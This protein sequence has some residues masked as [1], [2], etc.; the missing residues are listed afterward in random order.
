MSPGYKLEH[1]WLPKVNVFREHLVK[2]VSWSLTEG[3]HLMDHDETMDTPHIL[4]CF[5]SIR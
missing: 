4:S 1:V 5:M 3:L 2:P